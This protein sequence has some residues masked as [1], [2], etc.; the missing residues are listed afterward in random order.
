MIKNFTF[1]LLLLFAGIIDFVFRCNL[2]AQPCYDFLQNHLPFRPL[3]SSTSSLASVLRTGSRYA[4]N[5]RWTAIERINYVRGHNAI[6]ELKEQTNCDYFSHHRG[7]LLFASAK[8]VAGLGKAGGD[9]TG[10]SDKAGQ[11]VPPEVYNALSYAGTAF[12]F[13]LSVP[14][15]LYGLNKLL[16]KIEDCFG[17]GPSNRGE[18]VSKG[19]N[20]TDNSSG[21]DR[22]VNQSGRNYRSH[23]SDSMGDHKLQRNQQN[24]T[25]ETASSERGMQNLQLHFQQQLATKQTV[26]QLISHSQSNARNN[27]I[28]HPDI[29]PLD[30]G[31]NVNERRLGS[32]QYGSNQGPTPHLNEVRKHLDLS[33]PMK[34]PGS[35]IGNLS[36][37]QSLLADS[38]T[39]SVFNE[40][41]YSMR[42][43]AKP[44][45]ISV[46]QS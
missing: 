44:H 30:Q 1:S 38:L 33:S 8:G 4:Q 13:T 32:N 12:L 41:S 17:C 39:G 46:S 45:M 34:P 29:E 26:S 20:N 3:Y 5:D 19:E 40:K 27:L 9:G 31:H 42:Q 7:F 24:G 21:N 23:T 37:S 14:L 6:V 10:G 2:F 25:G 43:N 28:D 36:F 22:I 11:Q 18:A 16:N 15:I 35:A